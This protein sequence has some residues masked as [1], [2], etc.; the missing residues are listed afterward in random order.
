MRRGVVCDGGARGRAGG[1]GPGVVDANAATVFIGRTPNLSS[2]HAPGCL[3]S[4]GAFLFRAHRISCDHRKSSYFF[5]RFFKIA[6]YR[7]TASRIS[8]VILIPCESAVACH[9]AFSS[10][11]WRVWI[12]TSFGFSIGGRPLDI[13]AFYGPTPAHRQ[14]Q[15]GLESP[16]RYITVDYDA[17]SRRGQMR[18]DHRISGVCWDGE[19]SRATARCVRGGRYYDASTTSPARISATT[20]GA[21]P[22]HMQSNQLPTRRNA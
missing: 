5:L 16:D 22:W 13:A 18:V 21:G 10:G 9:S 2:I 1:R 15:S 7:L 6:M 19:H 4:A 20:E 3:R 11:V 12:N 17:S 8:S 14:H